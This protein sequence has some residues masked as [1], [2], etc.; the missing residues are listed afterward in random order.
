MGFWLELGMDG[1]RVDAV[2]FVLDHDHL[3]GGAEIDPHRALKELRTF[4]SRRRGDSLLLGEVAVADDEQ[5]T[6]S[7]TSPPTPSLGAHRHRT[8]PMAGVVQSKVMRVPK[9]S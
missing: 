2:P 9:M 6:R 4:A 7:G 5:P 3:C 8:R 1:F